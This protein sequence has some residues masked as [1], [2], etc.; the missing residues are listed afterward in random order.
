MK[1]PVEHKLKIPPDYQCRALNGNN[2]FQRQWHRNRLI[3][4]ENSGFLSADDAVAD[5]GCGSGNT[6]FAF[7]NKVQTIDGFD[8]NIESIDYINEKRKKEKVI[9]SQAIF[10]D[11]TEDVPS[12]YRNRYNK[13]IATEIIEH[14]KPSEVKRVLQNMKVMLKPMGK[15]FITTPNYALS[16]WPLME[17]LMD[18]FNISP[19]LWG[20]QHH[21]KFTSKSLKDLCNGAGFTVE[22][23]GTFS[24]VS[25]ILA[26]LGT[27]VAD[28]VADL[29]IK[30]LKFLGPQ[31]FAILKIQS[32]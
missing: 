1:I 19:T 11:I 12:Q 28:R 13:I 7:S 20:E 5:I 18:R 30:Y 26:V 15:L 21:L 8:Y 6:L 24:L 14:F 32:C 9:N 27:G 17:F 22:R 10:L 16:P 31:I 25:P 4:I 29:E 23:S 2:F 3:L